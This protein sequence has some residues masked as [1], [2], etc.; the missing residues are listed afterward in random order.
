MVLDD[1][2]EVSLRARLFLSF[3]DGVIFEGFLLITANCDDD[4][5]EFVSS[6]IDCVSV[7]TGEAITPFVS[8][9]IPLPCL[10]IGVVSTLDHFSSDRKG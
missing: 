10:P 9:G 7:D 3:F 8:D 1:V 6:V 2:Y 4:F 5:V